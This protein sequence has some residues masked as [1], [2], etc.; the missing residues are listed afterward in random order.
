MLCG[1][2]AV[3]LSTKKVKARRLASHGLGVFSK[4]DQSLRENLVISKPCPG[5]E[6]SSGRADFIPGPGAGP[7]RGGPSPLVIR[8]FVSVLRARGR[9]RTCQRVRRSQAQAPRRRTRPAGQDKPEGERGRLPNGGES[10]RFPGVNAI[11]YPK[12]RGGEVSRGRANVQPRGV[13]PE[14]AV[15]SGRAN[16]TPGTFLTAPRPGPALGGNR[17]NQSHQ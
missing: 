13:I 3:Q 11:G 12:P 9:Q 8:S 4:S 15:S 17:R 5:R 2:S 14:G 10:G 16:V 6:V 7:P 1:R